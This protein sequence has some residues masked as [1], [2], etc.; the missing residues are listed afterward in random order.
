MDLPK[1]LI[2]DM[3]AGRVILFLGAGASVGS[4]DPEGNGPP[5]GDELRD[6]LVTEYLGPSF[7]DRSL[8]AVAELAISEKSLPQVQDFI[9]AQFKNL[10]P[11][12]FHTNIASFKWRAIATTNF[13][14]VIEKAYQDY[15]KPL[16]DLVPIVSNEDRVD[17][18]L[19]NDGQLAY[20]KLHGCVRITHR[21][22]LPLILTVDQY[23][24]YRENREYVF[25]RFEGWAREYPVVFVGYRIEDVNIREIL[26]RLSQSI[27]SRPRYFLV[28]SGLTEVDARF[29]EA[30]KV[31]ALPGTLEEF[32]DA[33][34]DCI[35]ASIRPLLKLVEA[36][37]PVRK[38]FIV[39]DEVPP[40]I[41]AMLEH[42][43]EYVH[44]GMP[45]ESGTPPAFYS[46]FGLGWYPIRAKLDVRRRLTDT[47]LMDVIAR[48]E[49]D[50][51]SIAE[52]YVI[53]APAGAG[54]SI[55]L[56]RLAWE[57][58][59]EADVI[60]LYVRPYSAVSYDDL[61][62]LNRVTGRRIFVHWDNPAINVARIQRLMNHAQQKELPITVIV[63]ERTNEWNMSC[64][65]LSKFVSDEF[66]L[67]RLSESEINVL[68]SLLEEHNC[69]G[70]NLRDKNR[71]ERVEEFIKVAD[72][73][74]L[75][76]LHE[77]TRGVPLADILQ[78]EFE[79]IQPNKAK[80]LYLTVCVLNRLRTPVRAGLISRVHDI[81]FEE[82][83]DQLFSPLEH[84]VEAHSYR[85]GGDYVYRARHPEIAQIVFTRILSS[86]DDRLNEYLRIVGNLNLAFNSDRESFRGLLKAKSLHDLFPDYQQV[87]AIL[88]KAE[89][90]GSLE[91]YFYQ[92]RANYERIRPNGNLED[93][94][95]FIAK[96]RE[97][98][99]S[100]DTIIHT[101]AGVYRARA[102][103]AP[104]LL[105]R[106]RHRAQAR[107]LLRGLLT[108]QQRDAYPRVTLVEL[109]LDDLRDLLCQPDSSDR[110]IDEAIRAAD[111]LITEALQ[112][113]PDDEYLL[114]AE[115]AFSSLV[116]DHDRALQAL[117]K[118]SEAN[119]RDPF[120]AN[121]LAR[122]LL[123]QGDVEGAKDTLWNALEGNRGD[124]RLNFQYGE[125]LRR[126]GELDGNVLAYYFERAF[127]PGDRNYDAQFWLARY[128]FESQDERLIEKSA[129]TFRHLR[130]AGL[131][132]RVRVE[133]RD[134]IRQAG[135]DEVFQ[136]TMERVEETYGRV[137]RDGPGDLI[138]VHLNHVGEEA[139]RSL[140]HGERVCFA[141]GFTFG[142]PTAVNLEVLGG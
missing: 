23:A 61:E 42:D 139:W 8:A 15:E 6:L 30:K 47:L 82:F 124:M 21:E 43:V 131:P 2:E 113:H 88:N 50:R 109:E 25:Q 115:A 79:K 99:P 117:Q 121:R 92:Q 34:S 130:N 44:S 28:T 75:V 128:A 41:T 110:E 46:G 85:P 101:L 14:L 17:E 64:A 123:K 62:E 37:Q 51:P 96:A 133:V 58:A 36:D 132:H 100:D 78:D 33:L 4:V 60:S 89:E 68:V 31:T 120:I 86:V 45:N 59:T 83:S 22:E 56:R 1:G 16:Q 138:F 104:T 141:I 38:H 20:L 103:S 137:R 12:A 125:M 90:V 76:A 72:R 81:P 39:R 7:A 67:R 54:K 95:R 29:W 52:L 32:V 116:S 97:L 98:D 127:T 49:E 84:V 65:T 112:R 19:Q 119:P 134:R 9:A 135:H 136:G 126:S 11:A 55:V 69:L 129:D 114:S 74:L 63:A 35:P 108:A 53:K 48:P 106:Q 3:K 40:S 94:E 70:P 24:T 107:S 73:H 71:E 142:G 18:K 26:L 140:T 13:D 77:A 10:S 118:A 91:A 93:A 57:A 102:D 27:A 80:Q 87:R 122:A 111:K 5:L 105:A 66:E